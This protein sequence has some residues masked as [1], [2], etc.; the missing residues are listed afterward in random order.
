MIVPA[1]IGLPIKNYL[2][3][4]YCI[5]TSRTWV[6]IAIEKKSYLNITQPLFKANFFSFSDCLSYKIMYKR[7]LYLLIQFKKINSIYLT[8]KEQ[9]QTKNV[10]KQLCTSMIIRNCRVYASQGPGQ[11]GFSLTHRFFKGPFLHP[12]ILRKDDIYTA[13]TY[14]LYP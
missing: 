12:H 8:K 9:N 14:T 5:F 11:R 13:A 6:K 7:H 1:Q 3:T 4:Y 10:V 2:N